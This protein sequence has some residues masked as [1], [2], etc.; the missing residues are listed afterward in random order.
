M[1]PIVSG[2]TQ[3]KEITERHVFAMCFFVVLRRFLVFF[4]FFVVATVNIQRVY[5]PLD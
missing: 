3:C 2:S 5:L 4:C 1:T